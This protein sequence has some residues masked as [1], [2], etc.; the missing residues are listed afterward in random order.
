MTVWR[1]CLP[2]PSPSAGPSSHYRPPPMSSMY[3][4][5]PGSLH[6]C[7]DGPRGCSVSQ[8]ASGHLW[9]FPRGRTEG[10]QEVRGPQ[11]SWDIG[12]GT[13][14]WGKASAV[15]L[16]MA[17]PLSLQNNDYCTLGTVLL[18]QGAPVDSGWCLPQGT[19]LSS[20]WPT[21]RW[22]LPS[23]HRGVRGSHFHSPWGLCGCPDASGVRATFQTTL[24]PSAHKSLFS[25]N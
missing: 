22:A 10:E 23:P 1:A 5:T 21:T 14:P 24:I 16:V 17:C 18:Q 4:F 2:S 9:V 15:P 19:L 25:W 8:L 3:V 6:M 13:F 20:T 7:S 12:W 11:V